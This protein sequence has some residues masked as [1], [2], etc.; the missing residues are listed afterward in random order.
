MGTIQE[1]NRTHGITIVVVTHSDE[2]AK[3][4]NRVI[5]FRD[6][7]GVG[8]TNEPISV[9]AGSRRGELPRSR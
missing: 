9:V 8:D 6:G 7:R 5:T 2:V 3:F 1:L 4:A